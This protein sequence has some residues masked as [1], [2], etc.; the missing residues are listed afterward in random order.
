M[1]PSM[2]ALTPA[3]LP[4]KI[5]GHHLDRLAIVYVRQSTLQ[6]IEQCRES[7]QLQYGL[8]DRAR[9]LGWPHPK[10]MVASHFASRCGSG[11][12]RGGAA[13]SI[14][15]CARI[16][17]AVAA[18]VTGVIAAYFWYQNSTKEPATTD[19]QNQGVTSIEWLNNLRTTFNE[20]A[21]LNKWASLWTGRL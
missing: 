21:H 17:F 1:S 15:K 5:A 11:S 13:E 4:E 19:G 6:Q 12:D 10:V 14:M 8:A 2:V 20:I 7:T 9:K 18:L 16:T 3:G